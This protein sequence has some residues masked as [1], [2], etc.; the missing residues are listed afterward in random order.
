MRTKKA[1]LSPQLQREEALRA[2]QRPGLC[3]IDFSA[4]LHLGLYFFSSVSE[5]GTATPIG[6]ATAPCPLVR[7]LFCF[8]DF[9]VV[10]FPT[11]RC[12][13]MQVRRQLL[14]GVYIEALLHPVHVL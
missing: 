6:G 8:T 13:L 4:S 7:H 10:E 14:A 9:C 2:R 11:R 12:I 3:L 1:G 5:V